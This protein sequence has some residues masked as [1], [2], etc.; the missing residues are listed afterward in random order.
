MR[1]TVLTSLNEARR[2]KRKRVC[3]GFYA[4]RADA[5]RLFYALTSPCYVVACAAMTQHVLQSS[6]TSCNQANTRC[7]DAATH[8]YVAT[9]AAISPTSSAAKQRALQ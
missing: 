3:R 9:S 5:A 7:N 2:Y 4:P 8:V 1:L 6:N